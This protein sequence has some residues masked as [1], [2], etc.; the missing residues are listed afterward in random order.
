MTLGREDRVRRPMFITY[1][2]TG[3]VLAL[4]AFAAVAIAA[5]LFAVVVAVA[6]LIVIVAAAA[7]VLVARAVLPASWRRR[8]SSSS[9]RVALETIETTAVDASEWSDDRALPADSDTRPT[10]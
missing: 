2:R 7:V 9:G 8:A 1:R 5:T 6:A 4:L 10:R 3:G